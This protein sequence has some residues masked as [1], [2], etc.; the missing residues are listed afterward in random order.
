MGDVNLSQSEETQKKYYDKV[1]SAYDKHHFNQYALAYRYGLF[2]LILKDIDLKGL[3]ILDAMCG[4]GQSAGYFIN[5]QAKVTG[6]DISQQQC[7]RFRVRY[8]GVDVVCTSILDSD[9]DDSSYDLVVTDSLHHL[10]PNLDDGINEILRVLKPGGYFLFW[11]PT[12]RSILDWFRKLWYKLDKTYFEENEKS[13]DLDNI[14]SMYGQQLELVRR[15]Y[16]GN[17]AYLLV[18]ESLLF[19]IPPGLIKY[20][21]TTLMT[22]EEFLTIF[23]TRFTSCW[24]LALLQKAGKPEKI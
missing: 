24:V 13:I 5:Q 19:R 10:Y 20:Y 17:V 22:I 11:E 9:F 1:A 18:Q 6:I 8:P 7:D 14:M 23:Q 2:D 16:G 15:K 3:H 4:G 12:A 21:A